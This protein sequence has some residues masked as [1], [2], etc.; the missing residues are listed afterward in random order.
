MR[1]FNKKIKLVWILLFSLIFIISA[2]KS[3]HYLAYKNASPPKNMQNENQFLL[4]KKNGIIN[5]YS[6]VWRNIRG[7]DI[8]VTVYNAGGGYMGQD[9]QL[10]FLT[11][12]GNFWIGL[13]IVGKPGQSYLMQQFLNNIG[14][15]G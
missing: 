10:I 1:I 8:D 9:P 3:C 11:R 13:R 12:M 2:C 5:S 6:T 4:W 14:Y 15:S 7:V